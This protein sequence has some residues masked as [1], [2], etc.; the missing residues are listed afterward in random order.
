MAPQY[1]EIRAGPGGHPALKI[2]LVRRALAYGIDRVEIV[3]SLFG[4]IAPKLQPLDSSVFPIQSPFYR[5][6]WNRYRYRRAEARRLLE[7]AG[8]RPGSDGI[9]ECAGERLSLRVLTTSGIPAREQILQLVQK[10]LSRVG[11]EV[12][13]TYAPPAVLFGTSGILARG[14]FDL[15]LLGYVFGADPTGFD[16]VFGCG[17]AFNVSGYCQRLVTRDLDQADRILDQN[18]RARVLN[19]ADAQMARDV[20]SIPLFVGIVTGY[21]RSNIRNFVTSLPQDYWKAENWW[22]AN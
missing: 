5:P 20:P 7:Q 12:K 11:I 15:A 22:L 18:Q 6:N 3:R 4:E 9:Y 16:E 13:P 1:F 14:D 8:C 17:G 19:R 2:K 21:V 10:Q